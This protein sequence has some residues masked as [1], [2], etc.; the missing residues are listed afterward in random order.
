MHPAGAAAFGVLILA[1]LAFVGFNVFSD[2]RRV[3]ETL[4]F[5]PFMFLGLALLIALGFEFV[6]GLGVVVSTGA[7]AYSV[8]TLLPVDLI[9]TWARPAAMR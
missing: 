1:G 4:T 3:G 6:N 8:I 5:A 2:T 9:L 7:V